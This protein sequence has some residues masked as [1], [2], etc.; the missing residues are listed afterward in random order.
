M[1]PLSRSPG[2]FSGP[3]RNSSRRWCGPGRCRSSCRSTAGH[4]EAP[5]ARG[6]RLNV[7]VRQPAGYVFV[8]ARRSARPAR[9]RTAGR[10]AASSAN[11]MA[12]IPGEHGFSSVISESVRRRTGSD[13]RPV[14][15]GW[16]S[17][18]LVPVP[19]GHLAGQRLV[20]HPAPRPPGRPVRTEHRLGSPVPVER[21]GD[22]AGDRRVR[23]ARPHRRLVSAARSRASAARASISSLR[24][25]TMSWAV[26]GSGA[27]LPMGGCDVPRLEDGIIEIVEQLGRHRQDLGEPGRP[28]RVDPVLATDLGGS[29]SAVDAQHPR[30]VSGNECDAL[31]P[32]SC[33]V[34]TAPGSPAPNATVTVEDPA[35]PG[36][37]RHQ[38]G[39]SGALRRGGARREPATLRAPPRRCPRSSLLSSG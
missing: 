14:P 28:V 18:F 24:S 11:R 35:Q 16:A 7:P 5:V 30:A 31:G 12:A 36:R 13:P 3:K 17:W 6:Y 23:P 15:A 39:A 9:P 2:P 34:E 10:T 29:V 33:P 20:S 32:G 8:S 21:L 38:A 1:R 22:V 37:A 19:V 27:D 26:S 4:Q 25:A